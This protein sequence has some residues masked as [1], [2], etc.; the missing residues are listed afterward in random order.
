MTDIDRRLRGK[1]RSQSVPAYDPDSE[2]ANVIRFIDARMAA[3]IAMI[4]AKNESSVGENFQLPWVDLSGK[5]D[6]IQSALG[7]LTAEIAGIGHNQPPLSESLT[8]PLDLTDGAEASIK[9]VRVELVEPETADVAGLERS[10]NALLALWIHIKK[11]TGKAFEGAASGVGKFVATAWLKEHPAIVARIIGVVG[12]IFRWI[13]RI[14][15]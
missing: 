11:L 1:G 12:D 8:I 15:G 14:L 9:K 4:P 5:L 3:E 13:G 2:L 10:A 7:A 6:E